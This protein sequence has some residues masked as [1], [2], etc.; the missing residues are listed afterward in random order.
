MYIGK[1]EFGETVSL[2]FRETSQMTQLRREKWYCPAC[3][4]ELILKAGSKKAA[5]FAHKHQS[6]CNSFSEGETSEHLQGKKNIAKWC[7]EQEIPYQIE[8]YLPEL[9]QRPDLLVDGVIAI[10]FQCSD[11]SIDRLEERTKKYLEY[12]YQVFWIVGEKFILKEKLSSLQLGFIYFSPSL[13]FYLW[14]LDVWKKQLFLYY[15]IETV[16]FGRKLYFLKKSWTIKESL[17]SIFN[18]PLQK[19]LCSS[20]EFNVLKASLQ[21]RLWLRKG[22]YHRD[23]ELIKAQRR[24]YNQGCSIQLLPYAFYIPV[25]FPFYLKGSE[26]LWKQLFW[27]VL[28]QSINAGR[29]YSAVIADFVRKAYQNG[30]TTQKMPNIDPNFLLIFFVR[31][32]VDLLLSYNW[33][34]YKNQK[35]ENSMAVNWKVNAEK[36]DRNFKSLFE[37]LKQLST[38]PIKNMIK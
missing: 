28:E 22:L 11:L 36:Y 25:T 27:Q 21:Y 38:T 23:T 6:D 12:G 24:L 15:H 35:F 18:F 37:G 1:N 20:R 16:H 14:H 5:H 10:E 33:L 31:E 26:I 2:L 30:L 7:E 29:S 17:R 32:Y 9:Q 4:G 34:N 19:K 3:K 8:A 13:G